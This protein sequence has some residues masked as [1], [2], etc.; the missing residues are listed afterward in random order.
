MKVG[1]PGLKQNARNVIVIE[2]G[3][4]RYNR[5]KADHVKHF[6]ATPKGRLL[7][8]GCGAGAFVI[9]ALRDGLDVAGVEVDRDREIQFKSAARRHEPEA[10]D[11]LNMYSGRSL[12]FPSRHFDACYSW[13]VFEHVTDP[14]ISLREIVRV[15]KPG[16]TLSLHADDVRNCWDGHAMFAWPPYLPREFVPAYA[17]GLGIPEQA[18]FLK[19]QVV[20]ISAAVIVDILQTL[21]MRIL[22]CNSHPSSMPALLEDG[23]YVTN[24]EEARA[25]GRKIAAAGSRQPPTENLRIFAVKDVR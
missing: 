25:L 8:F 3:I 1:S 14:Q 4:Q 7:D 10:L 17:E 15:L 21:G 22:D 23:L 12:P 9:A 20:Y 18:E 13:F 19:E 5:F 11:C 16:A 2:R 6:G 24:E